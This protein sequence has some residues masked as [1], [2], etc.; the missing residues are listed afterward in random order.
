MESPSVQ[1]QKMKRS[2]Q[3]PQLKVYGNL[4]A[5]TLGGTGSVDDGG[6][7]PGIDKTG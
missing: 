1:Q 5:I 7:G 6:G 4:A 3:P 2:Y